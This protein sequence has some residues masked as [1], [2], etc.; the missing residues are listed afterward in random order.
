MSSVKGIMLLGFS[1]QKKLSSCIGVV[2][3]PQQLVGNTAVGWSGLAEPIVKKYF[4]FLLLAA[5]LFMNNFVGVASSTPKA[6]AWQ[7][8]FM[9]HHPTAEEKPVVQKRLA[10]ALEELSALIYHSLWEKKPQF[11]RVVHSGNLA[12]VFRTGL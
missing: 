5:A 3:C 10:R 1:R 2:T 11:L 4:C 8:L 6:P 12:P 9:V 7:E